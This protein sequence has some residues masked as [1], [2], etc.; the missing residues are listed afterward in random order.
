[1]DGSPDKRL[2]IKSIGHQKGNRV[3]RVIL[4][5]LKK[6]EDWPEYLEAALAGHKKLGHLKP[7][8]ALDKAER[9]PTTEST[10]AG[11]GRPL[12]ST[13]NLS[14]FPIPQHFRQSAVW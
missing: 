2:P 10:T 9:K 4:K 12:I 13:E 14:L 8:R 11:G 1:M 5:T 6:A 3:K 7:T